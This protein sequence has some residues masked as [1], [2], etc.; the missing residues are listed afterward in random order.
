MD[1]H[2]TPAAA[3]TVRQAQLVS[4][5]EAPSAFNG[6]A[7]LTEQERRARFAALKATQP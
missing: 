7:P 1:P 2:V 3:T 4:D 6:L 5:E